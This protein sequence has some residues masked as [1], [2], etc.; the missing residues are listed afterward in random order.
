MFSP[1]LRKAPLTQ[2]SSPPPKSG[3][4]EGLEPQRAPVRPN[5]E[6]L[7]HAVDLAAGLGRSGPEW[8]GAQGVQTNP[9]KGPYLRARG[10]PSDQAQ[11]AAGTAGL[12]RLPRAR[13]AHPPAPS[14]QTLRWP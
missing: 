3:T 14:P 4:L 12:G 7:Q 13:T 10:H 5:L 2:Y 1:N 11:F 8:G 6:V 9:A